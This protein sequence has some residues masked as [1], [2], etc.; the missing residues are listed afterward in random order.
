MTWLRKSSK[1]VSVVAPTLSAIATFFFPKITIAPKILSAL[2]GLINAAEEAYGN[3][4]GPLK[5][6]FVLQGAEKL[7]DVLADVSVDNK[8]AIWETMKPVTG[9]VVD[10]I[11]AAIN[12]FVPNTIAK[13]PKK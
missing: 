4:Q 9:Q 1:V 6:E 7:V 10:G 8:K 11:V 12:T 3:G 2:P 5:K 13:R